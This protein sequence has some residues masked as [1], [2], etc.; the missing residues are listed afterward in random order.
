ML[1]RLRKI[2]YLTEYIDSK[3]SEID[4][5]NKACNVIDTEL[6]NGRRMTNVG[7][8]RAYVIAYLKNHPKINQ[9]M[10]FLVRQ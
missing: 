4:E 3:K 8:F 9:N 1:E 6:V 10:T 7:T 2:Q 5:H